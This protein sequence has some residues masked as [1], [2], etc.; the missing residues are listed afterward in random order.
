MITTIGL[1]LAIIS[2]LA[3][4]WATLIKFGAIVEAPDIESDHTNAI[5]IP[6]RDDSITREDAARIWAG[7]KAKLETD[8]ALREEIVRIQEIARWN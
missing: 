2:A 6:A 8:C 5:V 7:V 1:I 3:F 4:A